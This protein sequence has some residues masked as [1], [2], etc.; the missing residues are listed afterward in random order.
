MNATPVSSR[1]MSATA[2]VLLTGL[3]LPPTV[4]A[5]HGSDGL[6][7]TIELTGIIRDFRERTESGGHADFEKKPGAGFGH[8]FNMVE[9]ELDAD[10]KPVFRSKGF[11]K[12]A[13]WLDGQG[14]RIMPPR[15]YIQPQPGDVAGSM[16][17]STGDAVTSAETFAQWF[18]D[19][20]GLNASMPLTLTLVRQ[21]D[22]NIYTFDDKLDPTFASLGGFFPINGQ[23]LGNSAGENRNFHFTFELETEF[24]YEEGA[25]HL[26]TFTGDDDVWVFIDG[27]LVIDLGGVHAAVSQSIDLDRLGWLEDGKK[28]KLKFFFAERHRTQSNFRIDTTLLLR[29]VEPPSVTALYD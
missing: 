18:R 22:S 19:V 21:G 13:D 3:A 29:T 6:P 12:T 15:E 10:G 11:K 27:R 25:G 7:E 1:T 2:F 23:L 4:L 8:Y 17:S 28:Y 9:D 26:F 5:Q 16:Q 20:P 14:R 24:V